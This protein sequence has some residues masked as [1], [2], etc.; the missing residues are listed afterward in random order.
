MKLLWCELDDY[1]DFCIPAAV[2]LEVGILKCWVSSFWVKQW[3]E[4]SKCCALITL[5]EAKKL[6]G[7]EFNLLNC[8]MHTKGYISLNSIPAHLLKKGHGITG[9]ISFRRPGV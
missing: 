4:G 9:L 8:Y 7:Y 6:S 3:S 5:E 1:P 2:K